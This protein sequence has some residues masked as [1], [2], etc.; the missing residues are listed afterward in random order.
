MLDDVRPIWVVSMFVALIW[1]RS[2]TLSFLDAGRAD[3]PEWAWRRWL[4]GRAETVLWG[5]LHGRDDCCRW[6]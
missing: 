3:R 4:R 5:R 6:I 1:E 2:R